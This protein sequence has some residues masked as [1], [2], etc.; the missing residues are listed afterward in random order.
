VICQIS[1]IAIKRWR[2]I[3][4]DQD[5]ASLAQE[6]LFRR[7]EASRYLV[8]TW[9]IP[10]S[11]GALAKLAVVGGGPEYRK[12]GRTPLYPQDALDEYARSKLSRRVRKTAELRNCAPGAPSNQ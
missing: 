10:C 8:E 4:M 7:A 5:I 12:A 2:T 1:S 6:R 9:R 11:A 3:F